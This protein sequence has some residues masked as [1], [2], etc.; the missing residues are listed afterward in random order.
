MFYGLLSRVQALKRFVAIKGT[1]VA[2]MQAGQVGYTLV[3][4]ICLDPTGRY[5]LKPDY[6]ISKRSSPWPASRINVRVERRWDGCY[7]F[8]TDAQRMRAPKRKADEH[9]VPTRIIR[10]LE[11]DER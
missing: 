3:G 5:W 7:T 4:A 2:T 1:T 6:P 9:S 11:R 10:H 8:A